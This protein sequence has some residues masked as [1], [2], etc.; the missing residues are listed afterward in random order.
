MLDDIVNTIG[1]CVMKFFAGVGFVFFAM[2]GAG[3]V[4]VAY[5]DAGQ[6]AVALVYVAMM[7]AYYFMDLEGDWTIGNRPV[8]VVVVSNTVLLLT[9]GCG[10]IVVLGW[11]WMLWLPLILAGFSTGM[12]VYLRHMR[13]HLIYLK[14]RT[15]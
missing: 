12:Q 10:T 9:V 2:L 3:L 8:W 13:A 15:E 4:D 7:A 14:T 11:S 1:D 5:K 6:F